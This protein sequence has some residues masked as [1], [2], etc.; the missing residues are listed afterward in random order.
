MFRKTFEKVMMLDPGFLGLLYQAKMDKSKLVENPALRFLTGEYQFNQAM[1]FM[2][3]GRATSNISP[4]NNVI[5]EKLGREKIP[6]LH[7][8]VR[9]Q[10]RWLRSWFSKKIRSQTACQPKAC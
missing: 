10:S 3:G 4:L 9:V 5:K 6:R 8:G 7:H 1:I 2:I